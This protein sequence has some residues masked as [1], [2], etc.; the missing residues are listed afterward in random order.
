V[1][2]DLTGVGCTGCRAGWLFREPD[3]CQT[4]P[5]IAQSSATYRLM[6]SQLRCFQN[7]L[8]PWDN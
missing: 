7:I 4:V 5:E 8:Q 6:D 2:A 3:G 1:V